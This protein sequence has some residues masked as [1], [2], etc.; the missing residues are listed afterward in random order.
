MAGNLPV[1][2]GVEAKLVFTKLGVPFALNI[3]HFEHTVGQLHS[4][5]RAD[6]RLNSV[7]ALPRFKQIVGE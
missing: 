4:Q 2:Q 5:A 6:Q 1:P 7:R 3:L